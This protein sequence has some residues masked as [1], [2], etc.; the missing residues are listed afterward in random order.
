MISWIYGYA[1]LIGLSASFHCIGMCGPIAMAV[2][3]QR[4][5]FLKT[6]YGVL[7]YNLGRIFS[8]T[9]IG[10]LVGFIGLT[11]NLIGILQVLSIVSGVIILIVAWNKSILNKIGI[12]L[13][14][15]SLLSK[16]M[17]K[18]LHLKSNYRVALFGLINGLLPCGMVY[19]G[20]SNAAI[21]G[22]PYYSAIAM[23]FFGLGTLPLMFFVTWSA[24]KVSQ[25]FRNK[26]N[27][28]LPI[29][30]TLVGLSLILRGLNLGIPY[31]SPKFD[32]KNPQ[33]VQLEECHSPMTQ[34]IK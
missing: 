1:F 17:G 34:P 32:W 12:N 21:T 20:L 23:V 33:E 14:F 16:A 4:T 30:L 26:L 15:N 9:I 7:V 18:V 5:S 28:F 31:V 3:V 6:L 27:K 29:L 8:Y 10:F 2:P 25:E 19:L 22:S 13:S 11:A 24:H